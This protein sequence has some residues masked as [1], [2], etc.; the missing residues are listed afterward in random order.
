MDSLELI[1]LTAFHCNA[2]QSALATHGWAELH[3]FGICLIKAILGYHHPIS[4]TQQ[5]HK[6]PLKFYQNSQA[7]AQSEQQ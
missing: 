3:Q 4:L 2:A 7:M 1:T 6:I 5:L